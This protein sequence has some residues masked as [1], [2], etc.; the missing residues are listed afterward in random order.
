MPE[1]KFFLFLW[2]FM[3]FKENS[4][5]V[6]SIY[7]LSLCGWWVNFVLGQFCAAKIEYHRLPG[8]WWA[9]EIYLTCG[10]ESW[11]IQDQGATACKGWQRTSRGWGQ[12][13]LT[14]SPKVERSPTDQRKDPIHLGHPLRLL[15]LLTEP[16]HK[17]FPSVSCSLC[18]VT[19]GVSGR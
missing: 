19:V 12:G 6:G 13:V 8:W 16:H 14:Y 15:R 1:R 2:S 11:A 5:W 10:S 17:E 3:S 9:I 18:L 4:L 7:F